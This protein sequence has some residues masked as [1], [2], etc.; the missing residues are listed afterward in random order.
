MRQWMRKRYW[1]KTVVG[2]V[3]FALVISGMS[4]DVQA[5]GKHYVKLKK[6]KV[7][8]VEG[9]RV[10][11]KLVKKNIKKIKSV[12]WK[13]KNK[14]IAVVSSKGVIKGKKVGKTTVSCTIRYQKRASKKVYKKVLRC[15]VTVKATA[16]GADTATPDVGNSPVVVSNHPTPT[17]GTA[18]ANSPSV[19]Q[20]PA[21]PP[22][23]T[24]SSG[25]E[26]PGVENP[27][28][29]KDTTTPSDIPKPVVSAKP[30]PQES[31]KPGEVAADDLSFSRDSGVYEGAFELTMTSKV[32]ASIFY[33]TDGS[34][35]RTSDTR[36]VYTA[37]VTVKN[38]KG[39]ANVLAAISPDL[40]DTMN[41]RIDGRNIT[42]N[43]KAPSN[44]DVD[45]GT[46]IRAVSCGS[47]G[48]SS[49]VVSKTYFIGKMSE[50]IENIAQSA[51]AAGQKLAV[52]SITMEKKDLF[53]HE[54]GIYVKGK[55][56]ED[57]LNQYIER[58]GNLNQVEVE[59]DLTSNFKQKGRGWERECHMEYFE[60][61][62]TS[63]TCELSQDCGI[64][65][66]GNYSRENVQKSFRLYARA[67]YGT[68]N[69]KYPFFGSELK[70]DFG[71]TMQK[72]KTLV[73][74]N[75][76][77]DAFNYKYK[78]ILT[79]SFVHDRA[80]ETLH[81]RPCVLYLN[82]EYWGYYV[83]QDDMSD[84]FLEEKHG[85][86]KDQVVLYKGSDEAKYANYGYKLDEGELPQ[87]VTEE[88]YYL[89]DTLEYLDTHNFSDDAVYKEF[90]ENYL[91]EQSATDYYATMI[92]LNNGYDWPG[93][94]WSIW[95]TTVKNTANA[96]SDNRWRFC[97]F[98]LDLTTEPTW[99]G[100][101]NGAWRKNPIPDLAQR[102]SSNVIKKLFGNLM[103]N[104]VF[105][106]NLADTIVE[107]GNHNY[108]VSAVE[109]RAEVYKKMYS[110]L[111]NQF[112]RRFNSN[113]A[114]WSN[115]DGCHNANLSFLRQRPSYMSTL[116]SY[117][118]TYSPEASVDPI[119]PGMTDST[120]VWEGSWTRGGSSNKTVS[121][122][123]G[124][125]TQ[126]DDNNYI[127]ITVEDWNLFS[128][129]VI[130][131]MVAD[132][133]GSDCRLH[134]WDSGKKKMDEYVYQS[135]TQWIGQEISI[136]ALRGETF[137]INVNDATL[138]KFEIYNRK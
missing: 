126:R 33:T 88:D 28:M 15:Q 75:G 103:D 58:Y 90:M 128:D 39:D 29:P 95:R 99:S 115:G 81:G 36:K 68:K 21:V 30:L 135:Q 16:Q 47:D 116:V 125:T 25:E 60:S 24:K 120:L 130:K 52:I 65:I 98:D 123:R 31:K 70:D 23:A 49:D 69:F 59:H 5:A 87:G 44:A 107:I 111:S 79:Q 124:L 51:S 134:I 13:A 19:T 97:L 27:E 89:K 7:S 66:Q 45:K 129:P 85:V 137:Y 91:D 71:Q 42:S 40:F 82:G 64:R 17:D 41:Y 105:R 20:N 96:Y 93:K 136:G 4:M 11:L 8:V 3:L 67:D 14:K 109:Q 26:T 62:G 56:F 106:Q 50:H 37:G 38:R 6:T 34:D 76:G 46:V 73:L 118:K 72:F 83:L 100:G 86:N 121:E 78:D 10:S 53:D 108:A 22:V 74:R 102:N 18:A 110:V 57:S 133:Y 131:F 92:Y 55:C 63:T 32:G 1:K 101:D 122:T 2:F 77:N 127:Q 114:V 54:T 113:G 9:K 119:R 138:T 12:K 61:D 48:S 117:I 112:M 104:A 43:C 80:Y 94:N 84:N 132:G 35:P